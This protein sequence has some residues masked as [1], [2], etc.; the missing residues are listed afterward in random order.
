M[1]VSTC[2]ERQMYDITYVRNVK[3]DSSELIYKTETDSQIRK[4][5][6]LLPE[7][8]RRE[9]AREQGGGARQGGGGRRKRAGT[10]PRR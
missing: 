10:G 6:L 5:S 2:T 7:G 4:T 1:S 8:K 9:G 3:S